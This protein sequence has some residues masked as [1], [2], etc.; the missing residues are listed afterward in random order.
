MP[1]S[2]FARIQNLSERDFDSIQTLAKSMDMRILDRGLYQTVE[3]SDRFTAIT[4]EFHL[5]GRFHRIVQEVWKDVDEVFE[6]HPILGDFNLKA[7]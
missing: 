4:I 1:Y 5:D 7:K 3:W 2:V 6:R